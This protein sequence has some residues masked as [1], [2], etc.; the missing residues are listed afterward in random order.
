MS[1]QS[2]SYSVLKIISL[3]VV[4]G[5]VSFLSFTNLLMGS[6]SGCRQ[7]EEKFLS[8]ICGNSVGKIL[9]DW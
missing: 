9:V 4:L 1:T 2:I 7:S 5:L 6:L 8:V 3:L